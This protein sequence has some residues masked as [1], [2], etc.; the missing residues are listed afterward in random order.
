MIVKG[1]AE[2][3]NDEGPSVITEEGPYI[4]DKSAVRIGEGFRIHG[5]GVVLLI[6][7]VYIM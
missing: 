1:R 7:H 6:Q 3:K 2:E 5:V 4:P